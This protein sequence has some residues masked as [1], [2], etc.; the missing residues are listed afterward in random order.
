MG[1]ITGSIELGK[2]AD[3]IVFDRNLFNCDPQNLA[4]TK[5]LEAYFEGRKSA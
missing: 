2:P 4:D 3:L 5:V 1:E